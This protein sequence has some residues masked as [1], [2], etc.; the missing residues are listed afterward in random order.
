MEDFSEL[1]KCVI[2]LENLTKLGILLDEAIGDLNIYNDILAR[3][4]NLKSF[5]LS[6]G[7]NQAGVSG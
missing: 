6:L 5:T 3:K 4:P 7:N 1:V 2:P